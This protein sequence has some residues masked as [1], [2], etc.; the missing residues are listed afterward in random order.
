VAFPTLQYAITCRK[1]TIALILI[2][3]LRENLED[4]NNDFQTALHVAIEYG[5][6]DV[7]IKLLKN[8]ANA[9]V[10]DKVYVEPFFF[11]FTR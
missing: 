8:G 3:H 11:A 9:N 1:E 4:E 10:I 5:M 2:D 7:V 6:H